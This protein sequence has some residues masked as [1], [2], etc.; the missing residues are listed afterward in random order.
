MIDLPV[1]VSPVNAILS[2]PG[3]STIA[4]PTLEPGPVITFNTPGGRPTSMA[5]SPSTSAV[6]GVWLAGL[7]M[8]VLPQAS[9]GATFQEASS[10]GKFQGTMAATT[11]IGSRSV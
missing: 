2:M 9:A 11:P 5:I 6:N 7:R 1:L 8:T 4:W 3:C 10:S